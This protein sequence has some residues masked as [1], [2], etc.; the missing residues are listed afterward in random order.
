MLLGFVK[1]TF[2]KSHNQEEDTMNNLKITLISVLALGSLLAGCNRTGINANAPDVIA[3]Q[4]TQYSSVQVYPTRADIPKNSKIIGK[5][6]A[7]NKNPN[8]LKASPEQIIEE[9][10]RQATLVGGNGIVHVT[11]GIS[12]TTANAVVT[13]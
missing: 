1:K 3:S 9:L 12:Q 2:F 10:K 13:Y 4:H 7:Q 8:G 11:P 6:I 5:V